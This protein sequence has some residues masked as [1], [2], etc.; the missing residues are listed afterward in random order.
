M[1]G[2]MDDLQMRSRAHEINLVKIGWGVVQGP[3]LSARLRAP[4][5]SAL[6]SRAVTKQKAQEHTETA[7][8]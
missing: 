2:R 7:K 8:N 1:N 4:H 5:P 3:S 6:L